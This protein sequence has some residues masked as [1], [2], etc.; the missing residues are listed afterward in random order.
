MKQAPP[1][2]HLDYAK[3][4]PLAGAWI[5]TQ[6]PEIHLPRIQVAPLAG[7]WIETSY[8]K[9][10]YPSAHVAPLAGAWI[11]TSAC[12]CWALRLSGRPSRGGVD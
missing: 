6:W 10:V 8:W 5:E 7:A 11:E 2:D 1:R 4:A 12:V 9:D 3:V